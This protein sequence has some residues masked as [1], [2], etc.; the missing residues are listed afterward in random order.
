M[1]KYVQRERVLWAFTDTA[2]FFLRHEETTKEG[3]MLLFSG[4]LSLDGSLIKYVLSIAPMQSPNIANHQENNRPQE[5]A[6][7]AAEVILQAGWRKSYII[8]RRLKAPAPLEIERRK[9]V[10]IPSCFF[11]ASSPF[12][13]SFSTRADKCTKPCRN[14]TS[15]MQNNSCCFRAARLGFPIPAKKLCP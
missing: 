12:L 15:Q 3:I 7:F 4:S 1:I 2:S 8:Y 13:P 9:D 10:G 5:G 6:F 11:S 14:K